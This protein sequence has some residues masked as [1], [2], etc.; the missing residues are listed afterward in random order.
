MFHQETV[1]NDVSSCIAYANEAVKKRSTGGR[2]EIRREIDGV[3]HIRPSYVKLVTQRV[4]F[5]TSIVT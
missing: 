1:Q 5:L 4:Y 3:R 2:S